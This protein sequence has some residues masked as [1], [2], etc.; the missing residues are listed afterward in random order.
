MDTS[1]H[2]PVGVQIVE[3]E[4]QRTKPN[5]AKRM[6]RMLPFLPTNVQL[7]YD[8]ADRQR[9]GQRAGRKGVKN[10]RIIF[11]AGNCEFHATKGWRTRRA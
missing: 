8:I 3:R 9:R 10:R 6:A 11:V 4:L 5:L 7:D 1:A 2:I